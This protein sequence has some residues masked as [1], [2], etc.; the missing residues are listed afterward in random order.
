MMFVY[1]VVFW[2]WFD[3]LCSCEYMQMAALSQLS[4][5]Q[6]AALSATPGLLASPAQVNMV[7][8][9]IPDQLL[10]AFFDDFSSAIVVRNLN[11][12]IITGL[13]LVS[14]NCIYCLNSNKT[15][16]IYHISFL[17]YISLLFVSCQMIYKQEHAFTCMYCVFFLFLQGQT[18]TLP[19]SVRSA[20]LQV[21]F[22]R[23]N[24]ADSTVSDSVV[25]LWLSKRL[26]QLLVN[27]SPLHVAPLFGIFAGRNCSIGQ[28]GYVCSPEDCSNL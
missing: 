16:Y 3:H 1:L 12:Q 4:P 13:C 19:S 15:Q 24:L 23:V 22:S 18:N 2:V 10:P 20:L 8:S 9:L 14:G 25:S 11:I 26:P 7:T 27:L 17:T 21:V 5:R 6:L 28:Q